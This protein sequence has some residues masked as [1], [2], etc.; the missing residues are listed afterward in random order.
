MSEPIV[1]GFSNDA[2]LKEL[3][4]LAM[5]QAM[6]TIAKMARDYAAK[7]PPGISAAESMLAFA[8]AILS[9]NSK[10]WPKEAAR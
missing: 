8:D 1:P 10:V 2:V 6:Q 7:V 3:S 9:T 4:K 5:E